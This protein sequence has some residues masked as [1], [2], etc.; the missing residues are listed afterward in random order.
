[1]LADTSTGA[2]KTGTAVAVLGLIGGLGVVVAAQSGRSVLAT[3]A[4]VGGPSAAVVVLG[5]RVATP[6]AKNR[7]LHQVRVGLLVG[8]LGL[9]A[10][11]LTRWTVVLLSGSSI[12]P[13]EA[14]PVFGELL[15]GSEA[16]KLNWVVGTAYH[17][18]NGIGFAI[19]YVIMFGTRGVRAGLLWAFALEAATL[20]IYPGWLDIK[21]RGEFT[22]V[23]LSGHVA[24]G[25]V[26]GATASRLLRTG[27]AQ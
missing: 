15:T 18:F 19:F 11:D 24:Y 14:F 17:I 25:A 13:F 22:A 3:A 9:L 23:S 4:A 5:W 6:E 27:D 8:A 2:T 10:Y 12:N 20:A 26:I 21:A 16:V 7:L 1:M